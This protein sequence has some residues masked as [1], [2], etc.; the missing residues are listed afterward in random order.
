MGFVSDHKSSP[1]GLG[2]FAQAELDSFVSCVRSVLHTMRI[3]KAWDP[4]SMVLTYSKT[5]VLR[6]QYVQTT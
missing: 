1:T 5:T 3:W 2:I 4:R 6:L